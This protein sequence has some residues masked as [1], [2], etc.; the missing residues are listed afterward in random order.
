MD[1]DV[2]IGC[3]LVLAS[4]GVMSALLVWSRRTI[5]RIAVR[6]LRSAREI[7]KELNGER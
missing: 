6:G 3:I 1:R 5:D 2:I 4:L 7:E